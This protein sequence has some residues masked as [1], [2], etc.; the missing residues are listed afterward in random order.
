[1]VMSPPPPTPLHDP[2]PCSATAP[3]A[4]QLFPNTPTGPVWQ[5]LYLFMFLMKVNEDSLTLGNCTAIALRRHLAFLSGPAWGPF[6]PAAL[7]PTIKCVPS[8]SAHLA[9]RP[10]G[11]AGASPNPRTVQ[12]RHLYPHGAD[13]ET[14]TEVW[15]CA[16]RHSAESQWCRDL[17]PDLWL[18]ATRPVGSA[19][20]AL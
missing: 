13:E 4:C 6:P 14:G 17:S 15:G 19:R 11:D 7:H 12:D 3:E 9:H 16:G 10:L 20:G 8:A 2:R 5:A 1:M 18:P